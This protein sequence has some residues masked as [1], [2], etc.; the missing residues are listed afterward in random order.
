MSPRVVAEPAGDRSGN[1]YRPR[2]CCWSRTPEA[3]ELKVVFLGAT[4]GIGL[5]LA[6]G[7]AERG[8][9]LYLLGRD[10]EA[11]AR[12]AG[13]LAQRAGRRVSHGLFDLMA[14]A[15]A[16]PGALDAA[17]EA[18]PGFD[19]VVVTAAMF[20]EQPCFEEDR[21]LRHRL[22][23]T[24]F[25]NTIHFCEEARQRL[26]ARRGTLCVFSSVA[27]ERPRKPVV[28]Y[29]ATKAGLSYYLE[30][31]D[32]RYRREGLKTITIIPGFVKT[33]MT[34]GRR[35]PPFAAEPADLVPAILR[36]I[37]RGTPRVFVPGVWRWVMLAVRNLP[38]WVMRRLDA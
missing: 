1:A 13:E 10:A 28:L 36:A 2:L 29:G 21:V 12:T 34:A 5:A 4:R 17:E 20:G 35:P 15:A 16:I 30:G 24:N 3:Q 25:T 11:L 27:A 23:I 9:E 33:D 22:L 26:S 19:T 37:D 6:R 32:Y 8:D 14:D 7:M 38:R 31:L 18:L